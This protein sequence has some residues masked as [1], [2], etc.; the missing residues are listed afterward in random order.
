MIY[1]SDEPCSTVDSS[2]IKNVRDINAKYV[3]VNNKLPTENFCCNTFE[4]FLCTHCRM[5]GSLIVFSYLYLHCST[6][7][8]KQEFVNTQ[9]KQKYILT[10]KVYLSIIFVINLICLKVYILV[11]TPSVIKPCFNCVYL[12]NFLYN[13]NNF[14]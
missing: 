8:L 3:Y 10:H 11:G 13:N 6:K 14:T 1:E 4:N 12:F 9:L 5:L 2:H 7:I